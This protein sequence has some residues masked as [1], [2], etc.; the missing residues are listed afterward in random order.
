MIINILLFYAALFAQCVRSAPQTLLESMTKVQ[1]LLDFVPL[2]PHF[3]VMKILSAM[4]PAM[5]I[6]MALKD[7]VLSTLRK[8]LFTKFAYTCFINLTKI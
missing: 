4:L 6:S 2:L 3:T 5:R 1:L 7:N 8:A